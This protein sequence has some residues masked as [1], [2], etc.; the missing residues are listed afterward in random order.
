MYGHFTE[1]VSCFIDN[2]LG[3]LVTRHLKLKIGYYQ[4]LALWPLRDTQ[5]NALQMTCSDSRENI[6]GFDRHSSISAGDTWFLASA[7]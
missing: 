1:H 3:N 2:Q 6:L 7:R 5:T 4:Q